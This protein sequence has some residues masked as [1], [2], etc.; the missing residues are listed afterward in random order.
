MRCMLAAAL[1]MEPELLLLDEPTNHLDIAAITW[2]QGHLVGEFPGAVLC[3][4]HNH[5]FINAIA[6]EI[7]VFTEDHCLEYFSGNLDDLYKHA[8]KMERRCRNDDSSRQKQ[9]DQLKK[10]KDRTERQ[11]ENMGNRLS[12]NKDNKTG[13]YYQRTGVSNIEKAS[14]R[15]KREMMKLEQRQHMCATST[16][17]PVTQ[18]TIEGDD[19]SWAAALAPKFHSQDSALKFAFKEAEPLDLPRDTPMLELTSVS[20]RYDNSEEDVLTRMNFSVLEKCRIAIAGK[21]G[22][23]KSTLVKL[24]TGEFAPTCGEVTRNPN[25]RIAYFGQHEAELLQLRSVTPL[26]YLAECFP[27]VREYELCEQLTVFGVVDK[28]M[29]QPMAELSGGQRMRVAFARMCAEEPHLLVLD[30]PTN[31]LDI[32]TIEA[33]SDALKDFQGGVIFVTHDVYLIEEAAD[34][35]VIVDGRGTRTEYGSSVNKKRFDLDTS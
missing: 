7:I 16:F 31:H 15:A 13:G 14:A 30:E 22:A 8:N 25:L 21:N 19:F 11:C 26:Q 6:N 33:L 12:S 32:Y 23:G 28:M 29:R 4:S 18:Q 34:N 10:T 17:D 5:A 1:F 9:M 3:V 20:Y 35:V 27:K 2:L 24:L